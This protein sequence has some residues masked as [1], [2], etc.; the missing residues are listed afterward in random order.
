MSSIESP[1][2]ERGSALLVTGAN[3]YI[4]SHVVDQLLAAG[5]R[6]R[7]TARDAKKLHG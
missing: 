1:A 3:G 7:G 4:G 5:Y 2:I 6:V